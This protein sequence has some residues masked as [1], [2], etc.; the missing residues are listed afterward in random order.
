MI[1]FGFIFVILLLLRII[2]RVTIT[3]DLMQNGDEIYL[4]IGFIGLWA[5]I[6]FLVYT[7]K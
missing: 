4:A 3:R 2:Y 7:L 1:I 5:L 6:Y